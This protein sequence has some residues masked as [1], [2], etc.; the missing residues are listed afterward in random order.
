M[1][2]SVGGGLRSRLVFVEIWTDIESPLSAFFPLVL[3][4]GEVR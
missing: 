2:G 1:N 4:R 3:P